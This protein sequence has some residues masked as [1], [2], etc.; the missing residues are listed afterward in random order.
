MQTSSGGSDSG[1][2]ADSRSAIRDPV[3]RMHPVEVLRGLAGLVGLQ[4]ADEVPAQAAAGQ[5]G[6]VRARFLDVVLAEVREPRIQRGL[7][8]VRAAAISRRRSV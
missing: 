1:R 7:Q 4:R 6:D 2:C 5:R 3:H 8:R